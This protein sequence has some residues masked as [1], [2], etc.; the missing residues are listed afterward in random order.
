R[1]DGENGAHSA[2]FPAILALKP[3]MRVEGARLG[4]ITH[5]RNPFD[6]LLWPLHPHRRARCVQVGYCTTSSPSPPSP[7]P[8]SRRIA[9]V[10]ISHAAGDAHCATEARSRCAASE[11]SR[12]W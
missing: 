10:V 9:F 6:G 8:Q 11:C 1:E 2:P 4:R 12:N 7:T 3:A 5:P